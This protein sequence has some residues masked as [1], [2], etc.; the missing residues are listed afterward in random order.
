MY[1]ALLVD[2]ETRSRR[3]LIEEVDW[4]K[5]GVKKIFEASGKTEAIEIL[6]KENISIFI[7]DIEM[8]GGSGLDLVEW[9]QRE[10]M[11]LGTLFVTCHP[12]FDYMRKAIQLKC[13]D[14]ILKPID[15][16]E[17]SR[18]LTEMVEKMEDYD[19]GEKEE[20]ELLW[21]AQE[22]AAETLIRNYGTVAGTRN[23]EQE[24]KQYVKN[25]MMEEITIPAIAEEL[26]FNPQYLMRSFKQKTGVSIIEYITGIR[27]NTARKILRDTKIP[28][29]DIAFMVGYSDY[30]YFTR[31]FKR[32]NSVSPSQYRGEKN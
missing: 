11:K 18:V 20:K 12:E 15:Y 5:C 32:E 4:K 26:H 28:V 14:Y 19:S 17:F 9:T 7:C 27:M 22:S 30:A 31:V 6:Q 10:K 13:Y 16:S 23:I 3:A 29:R 1:N 25:H 8:P 21:T 24:V 2:D